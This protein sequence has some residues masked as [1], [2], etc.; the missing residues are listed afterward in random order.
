M[1]LNL[2]PTDGGR[3]VTAYRHVAGSRGGDKQ[4]Y[5]FEIISGVLASLFF[6][7]TFIDP[8]NQGSLYL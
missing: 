7:T 1:L 3:Q 6:K 4:E 5:N 2:Q 8:R